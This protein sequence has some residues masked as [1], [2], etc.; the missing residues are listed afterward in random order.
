MWTIGF[1]GAK[2][3]IQGRSGFRKHGEKGIIG[4][5]FHGYLGM[6]L[7]AFGELMIALSVKPIT[8]WTYPIVW[9]GYIFFVDALVLRISGRSLLFHRTR[10]FLAMLPL[11]LGFWLIFEFYNLFLHNWRYVNY[12]T[13][14]WVML[15]GFGV[16]FATVVLII[17]ETSDLLQALGA[18]RNVRVKRQA[19]TPRLLTTLVVVGSLFLIIPLLFPSHYLFAPVWVGFIFLLDPINYKMGGESLLR[20]LE[21]GRSQKSLCLMASGVITG[22][23][24]EFWNYWA[25]SK[26]VYT[27]PITENIKIFE[28][29]VAGY[30][31]FIP[32]ALELYV[33]YY[34]IKMIYE[35]QSGTGSRP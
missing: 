33:M 35:R 13:E 7:I 10:E 16:S 3:V 28:M 34:F 19:I 9:Y 14:P 17:F 24:W 29:P 30:L 12:P 11:G 6:G 20:E 22:F 2:G 8:I 26:W 4:L 32:F 1:G 23:L 5:R 31:G 21:E 18:F 25:G 27:F 15:T